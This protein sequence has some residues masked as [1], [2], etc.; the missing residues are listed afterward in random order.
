V[1]ELHKILAPVPRAWVENSSSFRSLVRKP[2]LTG[3]PPQAPGHSKYEP[4]LGAIVVYDKGV[5][6]DGKLDPE[7]F[8]RSVYHEL[9]HSII[10]SNP[11][12]LKAWNASTS[13]DGFVDDYA[14]TSPDEDFADTLSEFFIHSGA[15]ERVA[16]QKAA[17]LRNLLDQAEEKVAMSLLHSFADE[18]TKTGASAGAHLG[19]MAKMIRRAMGSGAGKA[20]LGATVG[21]GGGAMIGERH[22]EAEGYGKGTKDLRQIAVLARRRGQQEG[23]MAYHRHMMKRMRGQ[24]RRS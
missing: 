6:H 3:A 17:F 19:S 11:Q 14:K 20:T 2:V 24:Q 12:L 23:V 13:G 5:Y 16:P 22:G 9:A 18:L 21:L 1:R 10:R 8:R 7:Q 15:T 4:Q